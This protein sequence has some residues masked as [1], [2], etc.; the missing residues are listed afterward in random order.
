MQ[1]PAEKGR[2]QVSEAA[3]GAGFLSILMICSDARMRKN[4]YI[5]GRVSAA[6]HLPRLHLFP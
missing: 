3:D 4:I 2:R 6:R 5:S 1:M